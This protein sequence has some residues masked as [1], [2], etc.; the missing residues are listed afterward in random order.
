MDTTPA[1]APVDAG[2]S[3]LG[4][5]QFG[6]Q[7]HLGLYSTHGERVSGLGVGEFRPAMILSKVIYAPAALDHVGVIARGVAQVD[8][9]VPHAPTH[10]AVMTDESSRPAAG[11]NPDGNT[12]GTLACR[13]PESEATVA[14]GVDAGGPD[15]AWPQLRAMRRYRTVLVDLAPETCD[16]LLVQGNLHSRGPRPGRCQSRPVTLQPNMAGR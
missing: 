5:P 16:R 6:G 4:Y 7:G 13:L 3:S 14:I 8:M 10:V 11:G 15:P 12:V 1:S 2:N 9:I